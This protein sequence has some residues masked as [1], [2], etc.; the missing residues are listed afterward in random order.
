M[1]ERLSLIAISRMSEAACDGIYQLCKNDF[2]VPAG[3][4]IED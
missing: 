4:E 3:K 1:L 2:S